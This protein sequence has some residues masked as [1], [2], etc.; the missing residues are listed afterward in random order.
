MPEPIDRQRRNL[1][2]IAAV[3]TAAVGV[4]FSLG[5]K[6]FLRRS[7]GIVAANRKVQRGGPYRL[8]RHPLMLGF[9]IALAARALPRPH[10]LHGAYLW[11]VVS[12]ATATCAL[13]V[14]GG[15]SG[16]GLL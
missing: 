14:F 9:L 2:A 5:A 11:V 12:V 7:F 16:A 6:A 15:L 10:R 13:G 8:V 1:L 3:G 4:S